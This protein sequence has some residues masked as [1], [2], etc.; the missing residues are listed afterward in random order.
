M[1]REELVSVLAEESAVDRPVSVPSGGGAAAVGG[2]S[3]SGA[4]HGERP[5]VWRSG[6]GAEVLSGVYRE[7]FVA[8]WPLR[9]R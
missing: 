2:S 5:P 4:G 9:G 7:V 6:M 8:A 1:G 3:G